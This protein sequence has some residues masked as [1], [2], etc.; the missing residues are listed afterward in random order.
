[1]M[2]REDK[3]HLQY[4]SQQALVLHLLVVLAYSQLSNLK[5]DHHADHGVVP[6]LSLQ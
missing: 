1:M 3:D 2:L 5:G 4:E 6:Y